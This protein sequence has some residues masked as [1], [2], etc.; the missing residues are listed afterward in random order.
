MPA[1]RKEP[2]WHN[3]GYLTAAEAMRENIAQGVNLTF[4]E[5]TLILQ[6][7]NVTGEPQKNIDRPPVLLNKMK[8]IVLFAPIHQP[9]STYG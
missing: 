7:K 3:H 1:M 2:Q 5:R 4:K 6:L 9:F 8:I